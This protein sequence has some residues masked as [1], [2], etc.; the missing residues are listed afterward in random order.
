MD[1]GLTGPQGRG[2]GG[3]P[4]EDR[5]VRVEP[6]AAGPSPLYYHYYYHHHYHYHCYYCGGNGLTQSIELG[7][8]VRPLHYHYYHYH[9]Y[10]EYG[11]WTDAIDR[12]INRLNGSCRSG[13][14][15]RERPDKEVPNAHRYAPPYIIIIISIISII[16]VDD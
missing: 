5:R 7:L 8:Q 10:H 12:S 1:N 9:Y 4:P 3:L 14:S 6:G 11:Q 16:S 15:C 13:R 2:P